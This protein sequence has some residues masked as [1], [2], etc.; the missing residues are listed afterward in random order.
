MTLSFHKVNFTAEEIADMLAESNQDGENLI[1]FTVKFLDAA[2]E[3]S[4][5]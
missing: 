1:E 2:E 3:R 4:R 5:Q